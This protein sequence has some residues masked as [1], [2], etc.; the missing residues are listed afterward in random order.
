MTMMASGVSMGS[1]SREQ[2]LSYSY[3]VKTCNAMCLGVSVSERET[4]KIPQAALLDG[5]VSEQG[6]GKKR[7]NVD[8]LYG[9]CTKSSRCSV[10]GLIFML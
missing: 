3:S 8:L 9:K 5:D 6:V 10:G 4:R 1:S 7:E 2:T